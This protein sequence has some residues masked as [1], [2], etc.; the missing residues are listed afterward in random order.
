MKDQSSNDACPKGN[1]R[2]SPP[3]WNDA[4]GEKHEGGQYRDFNK[5]IHCQSMRQESRPFQPNRINVRT[6]KAPLPA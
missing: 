4:Q 2:T 6:R 5:S 1:D 3:I